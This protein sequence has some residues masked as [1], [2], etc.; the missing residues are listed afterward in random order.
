MVMVAGRAM[1]SDWVMD[2]VK[3]SERVKV[4]ALVLLSDSVMEEEMEKVMVRVSELVLA[5]AV[6]WDHS[7]GFVDHLA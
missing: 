1:E 3:V 7:T 4:P 6:A 5:M 2:S